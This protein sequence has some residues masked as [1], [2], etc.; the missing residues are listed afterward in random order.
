M[1]TQPASQRGAT[2]ISQSIFHCPGVALLVACLLTAGSLSAVQRQPAPALGATGTL[3]PGDIIY[4][5]SGNAVDGGI[6]VKVEPVG[7]AQTVIAEGGFLIHPFDPILDSNGQI[8]VSDTAGRLIRINP[9]TG[10]QTLLAD[11]S[12]GTLGMPCGMG[13]DRHGNA[14]IA[15]MQDIIRVDPATS[16]TTVVCAGDGTRFPLGI[17]LSDKGTVFALSTGAAREILQVNAQTGVPQVIS[18]GGYFINPQAI[19]IRGTDLYVTDV[20]TPDGNF[21]VGRIIHVDVQTGTQTVVSEGSNLVGPV[22]IAIDNGGQLIVGDPYT[23]NPASPDLYD[24]A[25]IQIDPATGEQTLIARGEG[26][27]VNP[28]GVAIVPSRPGKNAK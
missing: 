5:D 11:N 1:K 13:L 23:V 8:M 28:R 3:N 19:A 18:S 7:G 22:G 25:I 15:D 6:I 17:A 14:L 10:L 24:G 16:Q 26:N 27:H 12:A 9:D 20:A 4:A 21:G 2:A